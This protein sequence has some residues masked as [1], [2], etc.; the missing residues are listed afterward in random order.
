MID[1][2]VDENNIEVDP[3]TLK[4]VKVSLLCYQY[5]NY[6]FNSLILPENWS[7]SSSRSHGGLKLFTQ[8]V[9]FHVSPLMAPSICNIWLLRSLLTCECFSIGWFIHMKAN[10]Y[11]HI[12]GMIIIALL[13]TGNGHY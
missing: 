3:E 6:Y 10:G 5:C 12:V 13:L 9:Y 8:T 4:K 1:Y 7:M 11:L 2:I